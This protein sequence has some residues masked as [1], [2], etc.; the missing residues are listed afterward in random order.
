MATLREI[1]RQLR[2]VENIQKITQAMEMVAA[3]RLR[4]AQARA[5]MSRPYFLRLKEILHQ[6]ILA[7]HDL[8]HP[9]INKR[10]EVK[11][12]AF[13]VIAGDRGLC[14]AYNQNIFLTTE[15]VLKNYH[16]DGIEL[17]LFGRKAVDYF[18]GK[19]W[20]IRDKI[21]DWGGKITYHQVEEFT[22]S[23]I[24]R[25]LVGEFDE[26]WLVYTHYINISA[27][28]IMVEKLLNIDIEEDSKLDEQKISSTYIF[29][30]NISKIF[31]EI[32]PRYSVTKV[33]SALNEAYASELAARIFSM[34]AATKN[35]EEMI[36]KLTLIRNKIRQSSITT[37]LLEITACVE[38]LK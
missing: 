21:S 15:K 3:S 37:E 12:I 25:Y 32:L 8:T 23:L 19:R 33:Q 20:K 22:H 7:A 17:I 18:S 35:A 4:K 24:D 14:G 6:L 34:R 10:E 13:I 16:P 36:E 9:L 5:E 1:R 29:E 30:P 26:A 11:K 27:R 28:K 2:S 31:V 38:S